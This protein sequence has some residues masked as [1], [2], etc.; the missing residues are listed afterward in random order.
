M[1]DGPL[2]GL[3]SRVVIVLD[4]HD[5]VAYVQQVPEIAQE[6]DYKAALE[7]AKAARGEVL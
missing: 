4:A 6:P 5:T 7:A 2:A 1:L 3:L